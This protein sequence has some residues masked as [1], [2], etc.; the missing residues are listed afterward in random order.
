MMSFNTPHLTQN[1]A[2]HLVTLERPEIA[3]LMHPDQVAALLGI[4][5]DGLFQYVR[6]GYFPPPDVFIGKGPRATRRWLPAT[7]FEFIY[8]RKQEAA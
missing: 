3:E 8:K 4:S 7:V 2:D 6:D 5:R 1:E